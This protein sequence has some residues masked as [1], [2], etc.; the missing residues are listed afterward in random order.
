MFLVSTGFTAILKPAHAWRPWTHLFVNVSVYLVATAASVFDIV[1]V[2]VG[3]TDEDD[4]TLGYPENLLRICL[5]FG[6]IATCVEL[7][8][9]GT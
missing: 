4:S 3:A 5:S 7:F 1:V 9:C 6:M 8:F 2:V